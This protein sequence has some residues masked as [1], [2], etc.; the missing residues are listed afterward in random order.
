MSD[1]VVLEYHLPTVG[2]V[3]ARLFPLA[4][5]C[6]RLLDAKGHIERLR[7]IDQLGVIRQVYQ[8]AHHSRWEYV[9]AQ[10]ALIYEMAIL[11]DE[12]GNAIVQGCGLRSDTDFPDHNGGKASG[13]DVMQC[14]VLLLNM[15]H[16]DGTFA[17]ERGLL[18]ALRKDNNSLRPAFLS[19]CGFDDTDRDAQQF[20]I[21][22][23]DKGNIYDMHKAISFFFLFR[24]CRNPTRQELVRT[25]TKVL[26]FYCCDETTSRGKQENLRRVYRR[27]RQLCYLAIDSLYAPVAM[28]ISLG[29]VLFN[30]EEKAPALVSSGDSPFC[31]ELDNFN[32]LMVREVYCSPKVLLQHEVQAQFASQ[33]I[34]K[35]YGGRAGLKRHKITDMRRLLEQLQSNVGGPARQEYERILYLPVMSGD[36]F[37]R[38]PNNVEDLDLSLKKTCGQRHVTVATMPD[39]RHS[40]V[41]IAVGI[42]TGAP[43]EASLHCFA[44]LVRKLCNIMEDNVPRETHARF[45]V[46]PR[47]LN[48]V[49]KNCSKELAE[50]LL[51]FLSESN[52]QFNVRPENNLTAYIGK[53]ARANS[54]ALD[55]LG[56]MFK[57]Q[58]RQHEV[59]THA[60]ALGKISAPGSTISFLVPI[61]VTGADGTSIT[62]IDGLSITCKGDGLW[63]LLVEAKDQSAGSASDAQRKLEQRLN[64]MGLWGALDNPVCQQLPGAGAYVFARIL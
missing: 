32:E 7:R 43:R 44:G 48:S 34:N 49:S 45:G 59:T 51:Q 46:L 63:L 41:H 9:V 39:A 50:N 5:K 14:W 8:G 58:A 23:I 33:Y 55:A 13:A 4:A 21:E 61:I 25:L 53:G 6:F 11:K 36:F 27:I 1:P 3:R 60:R 10:L 15:G 28:H 24:Y 16:L 35:Q 54:R 19:N 30:L 64:D 18:R 37:F 52:C 57:D 26:K 17:T 22:V 56:L 47:C 2:A 20:C 38:P 12:Q 29:N 42:R 40:G 31:R 62:D